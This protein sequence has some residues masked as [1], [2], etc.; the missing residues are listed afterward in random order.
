MAK[1]PRERMRSVVT[2]DDLRQPLLHARWKR[3]FLGR[4]DSRRPR[5]ALV[6]VC[7]R[8]TCGGKMGEGTS[9]ALLVESGWVLIKN[10]WVLNRQSQTAR[11]NARPPKGTEQMR[12]PGSTERIWYTEEQ[13]L[14]LFARCP[15]CG[16][17]N[18]VLPPP[19]ELLG[20]S[21][22]E[23]DSVESTDGA[24]WFDEA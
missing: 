14:P 1:P 6:A 9:T 12:I 8:P 17:R 21:A 10:A 18:L 3:G 11:K 23:P 20:S 2:E 13:V 16:F 4:V 24:I 19:S 7:G 5:S 22:T 15:D